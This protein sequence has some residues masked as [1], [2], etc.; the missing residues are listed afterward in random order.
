M[1][2]TIVL[3]RWKVQIFK[4]TEQAYQQ[5]RTKGAAD[6]PSV[7]ALPSFTLHLYSAFLFCLLSFT[8]IPL[9]V[10]FV[11][12]FGQSVQNLKVIS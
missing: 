9:H 11:S 6:Y 5:L 8:T 12:A 10:S 2:V 1:V 7:S 4:H 3:L